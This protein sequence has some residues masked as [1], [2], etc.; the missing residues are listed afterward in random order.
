MNDLKIKIDELFDAK[1]FEEGL[2]LLK[3][4]EEQGDDSSWLLCNIGWALGRLNRKE[5]ALEYLRRVEAR[6]EPD[7]DGWLN[8]EIGWNLGLLDRTKEA[9]FYLQNARATGRDDI[10]LNSEIAW[11]LGKLSRYEEA[12]FYLRKAGPSTSM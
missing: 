2:K 3:E 7:E 4:A 8:S 5:E 1:Q 12:L 6:E 10:W 11:N 9:L